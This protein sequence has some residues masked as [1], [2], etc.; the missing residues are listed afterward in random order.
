MS[1]RAMRRRVGDRLWGSLSVATHTPVV[2]DMLGVLVAA[3]S[4]A[5]TVVLMGI[6]QEWVL[7]L[8]LVPAAAGVWRW[9]SSWW[10]PAASRVTKAAR[11]EHRALVRLA[12]DG[13][14]H[15]HARRAE[16]PHPY[17]GTYVESRGDR[18]A[19]ALVKRS[20]GVPRH[21]RVERTEVV[22]E[23]R[24]AGE[25]VE[26]AAG[27]LAE[28]K[29]RARDLEVGER[30]RLARKAV[31]AECE[32]ARRQRELEEQRLREIDDSHGEEIAR[33]ERELRAEQRREAEAEARQEAAALARALREH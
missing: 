10:P 13:A 24:F 17:Y 29:D 20:P 3:A 32:R 22:E 31:E 27:Y 12:I 2:L 19:V 16:Q 18:V 23:R 14:P 4:V 11:A 28:L 21:R 5:V 30:E 15:R 25:E 6:T 1:R 7:T 9:A 26:A 33:R 8:A